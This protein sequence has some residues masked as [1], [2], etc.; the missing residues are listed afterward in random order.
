MTLWHH[1]KQDDNPFILD[2]IPE[3]L[4]LIYININ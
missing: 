1:G 3:L 4:F 2:R